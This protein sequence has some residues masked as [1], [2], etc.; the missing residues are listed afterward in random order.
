MPDISIAISA[1]DRYS[2]AVKTMQSATKAFSKDAESLQK[3]LTALD[4][5]KAVLDVDIKQA[6]TRL[7]DAQKA[8]TDTRERVNTLQKEVERF[9]GDKMSVEF[10]TLEQRL[11]E[12]NE[13]FDKSADEI[14]RASREYDGAKRNLQLV[15]REAANT[16]KAMQKLDDQGRKS[17][18]ISAFAQ[19]L[20]TVARSG[21]LKMAGDTLGGVLSAAVGSAFNSESGNMISSALS[22]V[23]SGAAMGSTFGLKGAIIGATGGLVAGAINGLTGNFTAREDAYKDYVQSQYQTVTQAQSDSLTS[24]SS[25]AAQRETDLISFS[26]LIGDQ[27][28]A[29]GFLDDVKTMANTTPFLYDDLTAM[30]K[31]LMTFG[32]GMEDIIPTLTSVGDAGA[33]LG[34]GVSDMNAVSTAIGRMKS[35]DKASLEYIN[36]LTERGISVMDWLAEDGGISKADVYDRISR[37]EYSGAD[38]AQLILDKMDELFGGAMEEQSQTYA[39]LTSTLEGWQAERDAAMG[40]GYNET[41][42]QGIQDEIEFYEGESG[43][44]MREAYGM[45]G[46]WQATLENTKEELTRDSLSAVMSGVI[47]D[48]YKDEQG[49]LT[50]SGQRLQE[51]AGEYQA[52]QALYEQGD[53]TAGAEMG[54]ILA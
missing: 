22:G 3:K 11:S 23:A 52:A 12:A 28:T 13:A 10:I 35:S 45:I 46:Q 25:T 19:T 49:L 21:G 44:A 4:N 32:Y 53:E 42:K 20:Q 30:S 2:D 17:G 8:F 31:T 54:R 34:M 38:V 7:K 36:Q 33:A 41:R 37:G 50:E 39:G 29:S 1:R 51:L 24:G 40:E 9:S 26:T 14:K 47:S 48:N 15:N 18:G 43:D 16:Q 6:N 27:D 5:T